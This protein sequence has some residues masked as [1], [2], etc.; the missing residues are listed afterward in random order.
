MCRWCSFRCDRCLALPPFLFFFAHVPLFF[1]FF[2]CPSDG[3][4]TRM[5]CINRGQSCLANFDNAHLMRQSARQGL[6]KV[7]FSPFCTW[8]FLNTYIL[9]QRDHRF[10]QSMVLYF[11]GTPRCSYCKSSNY[12][13]KWHWRRTL[14]PTLS[15]AAT[16][17]TNSTSRNIW[18]SNQ[19]HCLEVRRY[20]RVMDLIF[21]NLEKLI[22]FKCFKNVPF[23]NI[24][25]YITIYVYRMSQKSRCGRISRIIQVFS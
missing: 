1:F 4:I 8:R 24:A 20:L 3:H 5:I 7:P 17:R 9:R 13:T 25:I 19:L 14:K 2:F 18:C 16:T 6:A 10:H 23:R 22:L 15:R 11:I 21:S 12:Y